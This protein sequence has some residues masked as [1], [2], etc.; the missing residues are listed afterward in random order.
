MSSDVPTG[1]TTGHLVRR[2][3]MWSSVSNMVLRASNLLAGVI[4]ARLIAPEDFGLFAVALTVSS[5]LGAFAEFGLGADLVR[6]ADFER[7]VPTVATMGIVLGG[8]LAA[9]MFFSSQGIAE[10]FGS[11]EATSVVQL[12]SLPLL[13]M[14]LSVVPAALLQRAFRQGTVFAIDG[15]AVVVST[16]VMVVLALMGLG[17]A[18]LAIGRIAGQVLTVVMQYIAV[19]RWPRFGWDTTVAREASSFGLPLAFAN[20]VS[21]SIITVDNLIVARMLGPTALGLYALAFSVASWPMSVAGQS[22]RVVALPAFS[23]ISEPSLRGRAMAR[24]SAPLW[25]I[26]TVMAVGLVFLAPQIVSVLYGERWAGAAAAIVPLAIF[27][28]FRVV[29]DLIATF[30][31]ACGM[32]RR[33]LAV[34]VIWVA[35]LVPTL[36]LGTQLGG[37]AGA[38]WA[39]VVVAA[40]VVLPAYLLCMRTAHVPPL[41]FVAAWIIPTLAAA[42]LAV[43]LWFVASY[44]PVDWIALVAGAAAGLLLYVLPMA[45]WWLGRV[46][47]VAPR[48]PPPIG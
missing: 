19:S 12:M 40:G 43:A 6:R 18:A 21:W 31:I 16:G 22:V 48:D 47:S 36:V 37:L 20:V 26:S 23:R 2:G 14:G 24:L 46:A 1:G 38:G 27:G 28:A 8:S 44:V 45:R 25:A 42:P 41:P 3:L 15:S 17:P 10:A 4:M 5:I 33:V 7:H 9:A 13:L 32:T 30:L 35:A 11:P 29:F 34:Q 39:H